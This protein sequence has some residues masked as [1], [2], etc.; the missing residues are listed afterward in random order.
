MEP[1]KLEETINQIPGVVTCGIF[2]RRGADVLLLAEE[3]GVRVLEP[4]QKGILNRLKRASET[5]K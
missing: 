5:K 4:K 1:A 3:E 2:A